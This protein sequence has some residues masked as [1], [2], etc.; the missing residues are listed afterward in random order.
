MLTI[1]TVCEIHIFSLT[2]YLLYY[3]MIIL[4]YHE[5]FSAW[6]H[7][8]LGEVSL[9]NILWYFILSF[10]NIVKS[11]ANWGTLIGM[12]LFLYHCIS[13][14]VRKYRCIVFF[15]NPVSVYQQNNGC[16]SCTWIWENV[17]GSGGP[18]VFPKM[19]N[20]SQ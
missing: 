14:S 4:R 11:Q 9:K 13:N 15:P 2:L 3:K 7:Q 19:F 17:L 1:K 5:I 16:C 10:C 18:E 8:H 20:E 6:Q 12:Y